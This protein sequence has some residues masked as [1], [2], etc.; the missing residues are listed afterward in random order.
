MT[1]DLQAFQSKRTRNMDTDYGASSV[2]LIPSYV[3]NGDLPPRGLC[4]CSLLLKK[5]GSG[6]ITCVILYHCSYIEIASREGF[7]IILA[8]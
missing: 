7:F 6:L 1:T 5:G 8:Q 2:S 3:I 4:S